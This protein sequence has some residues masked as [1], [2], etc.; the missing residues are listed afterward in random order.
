MN[1][2]KHLTGFFER[3]IYE[4]SL[5]PTHISLYLALFQFWN[6]KRFS[7]PIHISREEAMRLSKIASKATYHK[8]MRDLHEKNYVIY[9]PSFNPYRGNKVTIINLELTDKHVQKSV[10]KQVNKKTGIEHARDQPNE[11]TNEPYIN[12]SKLSIK[13]KKLNKTRES[14]IHFSPPTL[15]EVLIF[16]KEQKLPTEEAESFHLY[17][18]ANGWLVG[19]AKMKDWQ[20]AARNWILRSKKFQSEKT[21]KLTPHQLHAKPTNYE[22]TL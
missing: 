8:C 12:D 11:L 10:R 16:F 17:Y 14:K 5:N 22:E 7:N 4:D 1:Y 19:K 9:E 21:G 2:I 15:E 3:M 18:Q 20:A 6:I 13:R